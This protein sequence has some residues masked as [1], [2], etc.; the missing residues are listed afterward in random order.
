MTPKNDDTAPSSTL[1]LPE[2]NPLLNPILNKNLGRWAEVYFTN[3]PE[4]RDEAVLHLLRELENEPETPQNT[5]RKSIQKRIETR[6]SLSSLSKVNVAICP[7]CGFDNETQQRFCGECG[8]LL[9]AAR[10][11]AVAP[12]SSPMDAEL[13]KGS[14]ATPRFLSGEGLEPTPQV[15]SILH[16]SDSVPLAPARRDSDTGFA[17]NPSGGMEGDEPESSSLKLSYRMLIGLGMA[18]LIAGLA[19]FAWRAE[20]SRPQQS[21]LPTQV[22]SEETQ[23]ASSAPA[24][25]NSP[26][27]SVKPATAATNTNPPAAT[28]AV[29]APTADAGQEK[30][31]TPVPASTEPVATPKD[32]VTTSANGSQELATALSFL[33]GEPHDGAE[34][35]Q[36]LWK[37]VEKKNTAADVLLAGLYLRGD[38]VQKNCDQG[39]VLLDAAA[40]K[41]SKEA[42]NLLRNLQAFG[43]E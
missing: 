19:Y 32:S 30:H 17:L 24:T 8:A 23:P 9:D 33:N 7:E 15:G 43:C 18:V 39:R 31:V 12:S 42:A 2:L 41:G 27:Q 26:A 4:K 5:P 20:Q 21:T 22:P 35:A 11:K 14:G 25:N 38:G 37:A 29:R 6:D 28:P 1:P 16:L 34:A 40:D 13:A 10:K 3:P 36:W